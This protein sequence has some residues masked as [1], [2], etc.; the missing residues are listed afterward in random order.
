M[1]LRWNEWLLFPLKLSD[2]PRDALLVFTIID[3]DDSA[4]PRSLGGTAISV[5]GKHCS[6]RKGMYDLRVWLNHQNEP[7]NSFINGK[8]SISGQLNRI[9]KVMID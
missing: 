4:K 1:S 6:M 3:V 2:I 9:N 8:H 5:F 7:N